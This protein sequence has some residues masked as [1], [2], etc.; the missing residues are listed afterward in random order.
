MNPGKQNENLFRENRSTGL[1]FLIWAMTGLIGVLVIF[2]IYSLIRLA[3]L[4][5]TP[6]YYFPFL[7]TVQT[8]A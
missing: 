7:K 2:G 5:V 6:D 1:R 8:M 4:R 3:A